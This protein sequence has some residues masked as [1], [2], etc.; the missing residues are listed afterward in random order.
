MRVVG[1]IQ[2]RMGSSRL[3]GKVLTDICGKPML[4]HVVKRA[5]QIDLVNKWIVATTIRPVDDPIFEMADS[6]GVDIFRGDEND[7]L[8]RYYEAAVKYEAEAIVRITADCPVIDPEVS[9]KTVEHFLK[10]KPDYTSNT[11]HR[12]YPRGLDTEI[13]TFEALKTAYSQADKPAEREHVTQFIINRPERF[14]LSGV[15]LDQDLSNHRWTV[16]TEAD[17]KLVSEIFLRLWKPESTFKMKDILDLLDREPD[18]SK[19]NSHIQQ[20]EV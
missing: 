7:V 1:I 13:F 19:I 12:T 9:S 10:E 8:S 17:M 14:K 4:E 11:L 6:L 18:L 2:A 5:S 16:D 3:P 20:K 15:S